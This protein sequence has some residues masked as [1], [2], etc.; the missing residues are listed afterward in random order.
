MKTK[1]LKKKLAA[2]KAE[3]EK[4]KEQLK[5]HTVQPNGK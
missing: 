4:L 3:N 5:D 1:E 2:I